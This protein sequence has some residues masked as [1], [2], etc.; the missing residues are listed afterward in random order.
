VWLAGFKKM[1]LGGLG[2][3]KKPPI[4]RAKHTIRLWLC[5]LTDW[6]EMR[7]NASVVQKLFRVGFRAF[8]KDFVLLLLLAPALCRV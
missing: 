4:I 8:A 1:F 6:K 2:A 7:N 5:A 3:R